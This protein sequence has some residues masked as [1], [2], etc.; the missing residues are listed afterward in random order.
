LAARSGDDDVSKELGTNQVGQP[1]G[2]KEN[3]RQIHLSG[4]DFAPPNFAGIRYA[5]CLLKLL[6]FDPHKPDR[7][8]VNNQQDSEG[9]VA[10]KPAP[11]SI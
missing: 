1:V 2:L 8:L 10:G 6:R 7:L 9:L 11:T 4:T 3:R 5:A